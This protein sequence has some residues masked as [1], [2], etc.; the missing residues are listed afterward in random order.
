[1][2]PKLSCNYVDLT[3]V[4]PAIVDLENIG[5]VI[6][7]KSPL[8]QTKS[9]SIGMSGLSMLSVSVMVDV[10]L[11]KGYKNGLMPV[12]NNNDM[13]TITG[14]GLLITPNNPNRETVNYRFN[15][16]VHGQIS[17]EYVIPLVFHPMS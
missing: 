10:R 15:I 11:I 14:A 4:E 13:M 6:N 7:T 9:N 12:L 5:I 16:L 17:L 8:V 2:I 1:M 3:D